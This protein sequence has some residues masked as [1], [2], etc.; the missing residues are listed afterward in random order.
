MIGVAPGTLARIQLNGFFSSEFKALQD[1]DKFSN[2]TIL[3]MNPFAPVDRRLKSTIEEFALESAKCLWKYLPSSLRPLYSDLGFIDFAEFRF[4][5]CHEPGCIAAL[6]DSPDLEISSQGFDSIRNIGYYLNLPGRCATTAPTSGLLFP[7]RIYSELVAGVWRLW[8]S[9]S[10]E[11]ELLAIDMEFS[12]AAPSID[13]KNMYFSFTLKNKQKV[14]SCPVD[15]M[16]TCREVVTIT[17]DRFLFDGDMLVN[18]GLTMISMHAGG[19][20]GSY[21]SDCVTEW[22]LSGRKLFKGKLPLYEDSVREICES[23]REAIDSLTTVH[24][25]MLKVV[26]ESQSAPQMRERLN[27]LCVGNH[28]CSKPA[29]LSFIRDVIDT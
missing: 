3:S 21:P 22:R 16:Q 13:G 10:I 9:E 27:R 8:R 20:P 4:E 19:K 23:S 25:F 7:G 11:P 1:F 15:C 2:V 28:C 14:V 5:Q 29:L 24:G 12:G 26:C 18:D 17:G 6:P